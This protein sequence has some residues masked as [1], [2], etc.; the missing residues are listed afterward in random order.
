MD[1]TTVPP[2]TYSIEEAMKELNI[3]RQIIY[4]EVNSGRLKTYTI[5]RRRFISRDAIAAFIRD[6][7]KEATPLPCDRSQSENPGQLSQGP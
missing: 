3:S 1:S 6:R 2:L 7:E 4:N 5:G